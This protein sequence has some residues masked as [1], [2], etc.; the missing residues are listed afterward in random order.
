V[1]KYIRTLD[2]TDLNNIRY[3]AKRHFRNKKREYLKDEIDELAKNSK[4]KYIRDL[5]K[6]INEFKRGYKPRSNLVKDEKGIKTDFSNYR[7]ISLLSVS[8]KILSNILLSRLNPYIDEIIG[9]HQSGLQHNRSTTD[10]I[11]CIHQ[12]LLKNG[13]TMEQFISYS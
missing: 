3:E 13:S 8:Y 1:P 12:I 2:S 4:N 5:Y 6:I 11:F 7:Q 10:Q 9:D